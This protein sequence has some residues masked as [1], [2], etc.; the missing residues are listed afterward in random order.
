MILLEVHKKFKKH[1]IYSMF[2]IF[3]YIFVIIG[4]LFSLELF[5]I[6][7]ES[8]MRPLGE[9]FAIISPDLI[10]ET[11]PNS[12]Y[13]VVVAG[14]EHLFMIILL[15]FLVITFASLAFFLIYIHCFYKTLKE[16]YN[17]KL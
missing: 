15:V 13:P 2:K 17:F 3:S 6:L 1:E 12:L 8:K 10:A 5:F 4:F 14:N 16:D 7:I 9:I 11:R